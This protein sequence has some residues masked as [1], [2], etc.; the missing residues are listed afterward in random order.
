[1]IRVIFNGSF[2]LLKDSGE[3]VR[4][5][6]QL[7]IESEQRKRR[8]EVHNGCLRTIYYYD[9]KIL[10]SKRVRTSVAEIAAARLRQNQRDAIH[11]QSSAATDRNPVA[12]RTECSESQPS[13]TPPR[14]KYRSPAMKNEARMLVYTANIITFVRMYRSDFCLSKRS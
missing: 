2:I 6:E 13:P 3:N 7:H 9:K 1:M 10:S 5:V 8:F 14:G 12:W 11:G 4:I